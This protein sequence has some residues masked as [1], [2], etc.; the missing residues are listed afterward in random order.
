VASRLKLS[1][2]P[3]GTTS[4][5]NYGYELWSFM[6]NDSGIQKLKGRIYNLRSL[7]LFYENKGS[8]LK[9]ALLK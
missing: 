3:D 6:K 2:W 1:F 7:F 9:M 8:L 5:R 4:P